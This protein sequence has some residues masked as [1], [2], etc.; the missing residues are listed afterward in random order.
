MT[1]GKKVQSL[2]L[3]ISAPLDEVKGTCLVLGVPPQVDR[4][5]K[6]LLGKAF[7]QAARKTNSRYL[8]TAT[9]YKFISKIRVRGPNGRESPPPKLHQ[10]HTICRSV[11]SQVSSGLFRRFCHTVENGG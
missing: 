6:N 8:L 5:R 1:A 4:A 9:N 2:P 3:V 10:K 7:E 11:F